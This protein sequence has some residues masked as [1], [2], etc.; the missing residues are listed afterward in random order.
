MNRR[1]M[2][3]AVVAL[4]A[5]GL[6]LANSVKADDPAPTPAKTVKCK[7]GNDCKG[8]GA[9]SGGGHSCAGNNECKGKGWIMTTTAKECPDAG[10]KVVPPK[11]KKKADEK[12]PS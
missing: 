9:C 5:A 3:G 10:G 4:A 2:V 1:Q 12:A 11:G 8:K 7:G 6:V